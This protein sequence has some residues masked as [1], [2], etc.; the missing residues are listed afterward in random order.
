MVA[1]V[2]REIGEKSK[3]LFGLWKGRYL[4]IF[5]G[6]ILLYLSFSTHFLA[7]PDSIWNGMF[8]KAGYDGENSLGRWGLGLLA[9]LKG[10]TISPAAV[11]IFSIFL[12]SI[13]C[14][15]VCRL[16]SLESEILI[17]IT[18]IFLL[19]SPN[20]V[21]TLTY[22][23]CADF[24]IFAYLL[25]VLAIYFAHRHRG[26]VSWVLPMLA[27]AISLAIYQSYISVAIVLSILL[28]VSML[29]DARI[30]NKEIIKRAMKLICIGGG[31]VTCYLILTKGQESIGLLN[32]SEDRG[33]SRMGYIDIAQLPQQIVRCYKEFINYFFRNVFIN[34]DWMNRKYWNLFLVLVIILTM[35]ILFFQ[36]RKVFNITRILLLLLAVVLLP[37]GCYCML[38]TASEV[39]LYSSTGILLIPAVNYVYV[40]WIMLAS[41]INGSRWMH[42]VFGKYIV[43]VGSMALGMI[44]VCFV[45]VF[46]ACMQNNLIKTYAVASDIVQEMDELTGG[47]E[48]H[49]F[50]VSGDVDLGQGELYNIVKGTVA[51]YGMTWSDINGRN[52]C[53]KSI[54]GF[55]FGRDYEVCSSEVCQELMKSDAFL[56]MPEYPN[57][58]YTAIIDGYVVVKLGEN[59]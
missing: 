54:L 34:N 38:I 25:N 58:G 30:E 37:I 24:Y 23:Y 9:G 53:W 20:I 15:F 49:A 50:M 46:Q 16:L 43:L 11:T 48:E 28:M 31:G 56:N 18:G 17:I 47:S 41:R 21:N 3:A 59:G 10:Y 35:L 12:L 26:F 32:L 14:M 13:I 5:I 22:Y 4:L 51:G 8:Y 57:S 19:A 1:G 6:G 44:L 55:Y 29:F 40:L 36:N 45:L 7:N 42:L 2:V 52:A 39:S 33:F 27:I